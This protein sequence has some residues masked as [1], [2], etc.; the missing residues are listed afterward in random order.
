MKRSM[1]AVV[2][3]LVPTVGIA[4]PASAAVTKG[5]FKSC[6]APNSNSYTRSYSTGDTTLRGPGKATTSMYINGS[7]WR[8]RA[9][10]GIYGGGSWNVS[11][12]GGALDD[13]GTYAYCS[14]AV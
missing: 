13:T 11:T 5:G 1:L 10:S 3:V 4:S 9:V 7:T 12:T 14:G 6:Y 2:A 8:V